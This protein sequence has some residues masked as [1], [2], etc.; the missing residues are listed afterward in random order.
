MRSSTC[1]ALTI[2][3]VNRMLNTLQ[4]TLRKATWPTTDLYERFE[5]GLVV[6]AV[7]HG[8]SQH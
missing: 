3:N 2:R 5:R 4:E 7:C 6:T 8:R 1:A